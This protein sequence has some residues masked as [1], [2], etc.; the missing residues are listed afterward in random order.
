MELLLGSRLTPPVD[1]IFSARLAP[2][3]SPQ[4]RHLPLLLLFKFISHFFLL[5]FNSDVNTRLSV[6]S[7]GGCDQKNKKKNLQK[8]LGYVWQKSES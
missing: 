8:Y 4:T 2:V 6:S 1:V 7:H 5:L 3:G